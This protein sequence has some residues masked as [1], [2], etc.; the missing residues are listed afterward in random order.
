MSSIKCWYKLSVNILWC[1]YILY[2][3]K[4]SFDRLAR[5]DKAHCNVFANLPYL[6]PSGTLAQGKQI[7]IQWKRTNCSA[8]QLWLQQRYLNTRVGLLEPHVWA[9][10]NF[11]AGDSDHVFRVVGLDGVHPSVLGVGTGHWAPG[12]WSVAGRWSLSWQPR[13]SGWFHRQHSSTFLWQFCS[14]LRDVIKRFKGVDAVGTVHLCEGERSQPLK[15]KRDVLA[16][17][18]DKF[19][20][21]TTTAC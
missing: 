11:L 9:L 14:S 1:V 17:Y 15:R 21:V 7:S 16:V 5:D 6:R 8:L 19:G 3:D 20:L 10:T 4:Y 13:S 12:R 2:G 18:R